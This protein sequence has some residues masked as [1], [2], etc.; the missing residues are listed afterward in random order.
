MT[1]DVEIV[2]AAV[3]D[4]LS[5]AALLE[6]LAT[7]EGE[8]SDLTIDDVQRF[9]AAGDGLALV[10]RDHGRVVGFVAVAIYPSFF[11]PASWA[12]I[13]FLVVAED[14]RGLGLGRALVEAAV[15]VCAARGLHEVTVSTL[16][17]NQ[18]ARRLYA[19]CGFV[20]RTVGFER[21]L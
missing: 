8:R 14:R 12:H 20:E 5:I 3:D 13:G 10:A 2:E 19:R 9:V 7:G 16:P 6:A 18:A 15:G 11:R 21:R 1:G 17:H 4:A